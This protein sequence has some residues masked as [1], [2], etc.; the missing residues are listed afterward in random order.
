MVPKSIA[1]KDVI[2]TF[3]K[4]NLDIGEITCYYKINKL[5]ES[6]KFY[7]TNCHCDCGSIISKLQNEN[8]HSFDEYKIKKK[9]EDIEKLNVMKKLKSNKDYEGRVKEFQA[10]WHELLDIVEDFKKHIGD[11]QTE[12][13]E[14][15][16]ALNLGDEELS[17]RFNDVV[18]PKTN[19]MYAELENNQEYKNA[20]K[21]FEDFMKENNDLNDS[22]YMNIEEFEKE[23]NEYDFSNFMEEFNN[24]KSI[25]SEILE[26]A[27]EICIY[28]LWQDG[29][30]LII[31][32]NKE[33]AFEN[34]S[35]NDL[36]FM[37][38]RNILKVNRNCSVIQ[39]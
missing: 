33:V 29:E 19:E 4:Y 38:Y 13:F 8:V 27:D 2:N 26:L 16:L 20:C 10:K 34:L 28:P 23:I 3:Q 7:S 35:I 24:L 6:Y 11:Y 5:E 22:I 25:C 18:Y 32:N 14:R 12:E 39:G 9:E 37:S 36:V 30:P 31:K 15:A 17:K 21:K 1:A